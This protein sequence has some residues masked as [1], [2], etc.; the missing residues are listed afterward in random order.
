MNVIYIFIHA[1]IITSPSERHL[2]RDFDDD[3]ADDDDKL[4]LWNG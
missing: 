2:S 3:D 1:A 4:F